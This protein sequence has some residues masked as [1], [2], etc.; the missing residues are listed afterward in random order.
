[1]TDAAS[2]STDQGRPTLARRLA[3]LTFI[4]LP[5]A[6]ALAGCADVRAPRSVVRPKSYIRG[7]GGQNGKSHG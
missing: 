6:A 2:A 4:G 3:L 7:H 1:M 5:F